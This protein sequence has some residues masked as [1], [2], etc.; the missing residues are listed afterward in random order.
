MIDLI[1]LSLVFVAM[2]IYTVRQKDTFSIIIIVG[3]TASV[4]ILWIRVPAI[5][6]TGILL[7]ALSALVA[8]AYGASVSGLNKLERWTISLS[9]LLAACDNITMLMH[10]SY[11]GIN[12][13]GILIPLGLYVIL[14]LTAK[15]NRKALG[16]STILSV[17]LAISFVR[18]WW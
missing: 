12:R 16:I 1:I 8:V 11:T 14:M 2:L 7:Y 15:S 4:L 5:L 10:V 6:T 13:F 3:L 18:F 9:G 17:G